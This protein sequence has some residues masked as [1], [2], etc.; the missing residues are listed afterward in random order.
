VN[1]Q[2]RKPRVEP[3]VRTRV[4]DAAASREALRV[5]LLSAWRR[6]GGERRR[7]TLYPV[8]QKIEAEETGE[9]M[10][11]NFLGLR[12]SSCVIRSTDSSVSIC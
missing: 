4:K 12:S 3:L 2:W 8:H 6:R 11:Q 1:R 7:L 5:S 9:G 10:K